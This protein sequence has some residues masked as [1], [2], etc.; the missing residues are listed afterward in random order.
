MDQIHASRALTL[1]KAMGLTEQMSPEEL[2]AFESK[3]ESLLK[4][5]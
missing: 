1:F 2:S 4:S 3:I 5:K